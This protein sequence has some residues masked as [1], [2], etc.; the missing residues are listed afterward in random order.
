MGHP[1][2]RRVRWT[3]TLCVL[4]LCAGCSYVYVAPAPPVD[5]WDQPS[6]HGP[7][8][9]DSYLWPYVDGGLA[10][11]GAIGA[12]VLISDAAAG[13]SGSFKDLVTARSIEGPAILGSLAAAVAF[14]L[15]GWDGKGKVEGCLRYRRKAVPGAASPPVLP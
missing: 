13:E 14:A 4:A 10:A 8:C 5:T 2:L 3:A 12:A 6:S 9:T 11:Y 1:R 7:L 15:A